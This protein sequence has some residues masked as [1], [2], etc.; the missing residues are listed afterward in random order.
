LCPGVILLT[1]PRPP[2]APPVPLGDGGRIVIERGRVQ[3]T[4]RYPNPGDATVA[5]A[6]WNKKPP[7][8]SDVVSPGNDFPGR[9]KK[10]SELVAL[11]EES[12]FI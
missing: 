4:H 7:G 10:K 5:G 1:I 12:P 11:L 9:I 3:V 8:T 2:H 6:E